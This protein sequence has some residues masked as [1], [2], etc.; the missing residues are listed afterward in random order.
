MMYNLVKFF[1]KLINYKSTLEVHVRINLNYGCEATRLM[2]RDY[3][4]Y[5]Y[6][7]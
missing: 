4:G 5:T 3:H 7:K 6:M 2:P 1:H